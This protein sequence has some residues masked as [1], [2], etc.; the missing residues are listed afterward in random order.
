MGTY[1]ACRHTLRQCAQILSNQFC[2]YVYKTIF[3][4]AFLHPNHVL[5][6][7]IHQCICCNLIMSPKRRDVVEKSKTGKVKRDYQQIGDCFDGYFKEYF[8]GTDTLRKSYNYKN[9][10]K[11]GVCKDFDR[12]GTPI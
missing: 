12:E 9:D 10:E 8:N 11:H 4:R 5:F 7:N 2:S 6:A 3:S 1:S